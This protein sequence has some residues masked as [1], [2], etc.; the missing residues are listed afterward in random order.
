[1]ATLASHVQPSI[2]APDAG[3]KVPPLA[4]GD[5]LTQPE[6]M[7]RY[8][9]MPGVNKAELIEGVVYMPSPV[10]HESH[11]HPHVRI[12]TLLGIYESYVAGVQTGDNSSLILD[13]D[14]MPQ[15]DVFL[16]RLETHGGQSQKTPDDYLR[17][18]PELVFEIAGTSATI[19]LRDKLRAYRRNG[20]KEYAVWLTDD[21]T[22]R[23]HLLD[24][25]D[26][27]VLEPGADGVIQSPTFPG[28]WFDIPA[29]LAG[30][31]RKQIDTLQAGLASVKSA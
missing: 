12:A 15:P 26:Y 18:A 17:G 14:N 25:G 19:D 9:A 10:R 6:F 31:A 1:M 8:L 30:D 4:T 3:P 28:L 11:G 21:R 22:I 20:V 29:L 27:R 7:R 5:R 24:N 2:A 23:Y 16:R 13:L